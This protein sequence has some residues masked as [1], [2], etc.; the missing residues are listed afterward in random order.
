MAMAAG[1]DIGPDDPSRVDRVRADSST[2]TPLT[3]MDIA[4]CAIVGH[5]RRVVIN[6]DNVVIDL[7]RRERLFKRGARDAV[8]LG[9]WPGQDPGCV[10]CGIPDR[11]SQ[12]DHTIDWQHGGPT[13]PWNGTIRCGYHNRLKNAGFTMRRHTD[14]T[15]TLI[16]PDGTPTTAAV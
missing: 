15:E 16:R 6:S 14:G 11:W 7:G 5:V 1:E 2:G 9:R 8:L 13:S 10:N 3:L 4:E 12:A